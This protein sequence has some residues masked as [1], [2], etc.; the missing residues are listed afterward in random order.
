MTE[1]QGVRKQI[2]YGGHDEIEKMGC[3]EISK[4]LLYKSQK[5]DGGAVPTRLPQFRTPCG[6]PL[7]FS[8]HYGVQAQAVA[9]TQNHRKRQAHT[10]QAHVCLNS[11]YSSPIL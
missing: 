5:D 11:P 8:S 9:C 3:C 6:P 1:I 7:F 4:I 10:V 2:F